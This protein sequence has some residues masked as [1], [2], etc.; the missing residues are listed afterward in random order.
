MLLSKNT[1][2]PQFMYLLLCWAVDIEDAAQV[3]TLL[4]EGKVDPNI[5]LKLQVPRV[6]K[7]RRKKRVNI[8]AKTPCLKENKNMNTQK[9]VISNALNKN[10]PD[11]KTL[12]VVL[13]K[14][15]MI[16]NQYA[17][18][19]D[20]PLSIA[21]YNGNL[22]IL[23]MLI[24]NPKRP[25]NPNKINHKGVTLFTDAVCTQNIEVI[26]LLLSESLVP[27]NLNYDKS[28]TTPL[29]EAISLRNKQLV[30]M[31]LKAGADPVINLDCPYKDPPF[32][33]A[34]RRGDVEICESLL[35]P[36][37]CD[38]HAE[39]YDDFPNYTAIHE[40]AS[41]N[42]LEIVKLLLERGAN[43][44]NTETVMN[45]VAN[46]AEADHAE[47]LDYCLQYTYNKF[48]DGISFWSER[49]LDHAFVSSAERCVSVMLTWGIYTCSMSAV[50]IQMHDCK[51]YCSRFHV[52]AIEGDIKSMELLLK[53]KP[54]CLQEG[55]LVSKDIPAML[56]LQEAFTQELIE[57]RKQPPRLMQLCRSTI[58]QQLDYNP[59]PKVEKLPLPRSL[60]H[61]V[62][63]KGVLKQP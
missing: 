18:A 6:R 25:A 57:V 15:K 34:I 48:C 33:V 59:I 23:R 51:D 29:L 17:E 32:A 31:L 43:I 20:L 9:Q 47:V 14:L 3:K 44:Y 60:K 7:A 12:E 19:E 49:M 10:N 63:F 11:R 4:T 35:S 36:H 46:I 37:G 8:K 27:V 24:T 13:E 55:W 38:L 53:L 52:A 1:M 5:H 50:N 30:E 41:C 45:L 54:Q 42:Q 61:F 39:L 21:C 2:S 58:F 40:A 56:E 28:I 26:N 16:L 62:Q 22:D